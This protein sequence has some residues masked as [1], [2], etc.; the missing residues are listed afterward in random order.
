MLKNHRLELFATSLLLVLLFSLSA[1][2]ATQPGSMLS[3]SPTAYPSRP[4]VAPAPAP[5][6]PPSGSES[7]SGVIQ[8]QDANQPGV[9]ADLTECRRA[10]GVLTIKIRFRNTSK[11]DVSLN[12]IDRK[13]FEAYYLTAKNKKYFVLKD[14]EDQYLMP[15]A[16]LGGSLDVPLQAGQS[17]TWWAKFP[18]PPADV[19]K[20]TLITP[21]TPPFEDVPI[22]NK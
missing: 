20:L 16:D 18:A 10:E 1:V 19:T 12:V 7:S 2:A 4:H 11:S 22:T 13:N 15:A 9:V 17:W 6:R 21:I 3:P 14:S 8:S 5:V